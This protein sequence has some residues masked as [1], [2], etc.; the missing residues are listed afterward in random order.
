MVDHG[1]H[2]TWGRTCGRAASFSKSE[3]NEK[4]SDW[5]HEMGDRVQME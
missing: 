1:V 5:C 2:A 3:G 4:L